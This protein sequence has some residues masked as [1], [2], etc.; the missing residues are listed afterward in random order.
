MMAEGSIEGSTQR[1]EI[2]EKQKHN[3]KHPLRSFACKGPETRTWSQVERVMA[4]AMSTAR[5]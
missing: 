4:T 5:T 1:V 3:A 2:P